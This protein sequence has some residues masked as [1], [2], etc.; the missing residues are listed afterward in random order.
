M[1]WLT[2]IPRPADLRHDESGAVAI[3]LAVAMVVLIGATTFT[4]DVGA[5]YAERQQLQNG[6]DAAAIAIAQ[7]CATG[8]CGS[9]Q[10]TAQTLA[11]ANANDAAA[12]VNTVSFPAPGVVHL[13]AKTRVAGSNAGALALSFAPVLGITSRS[14]A[15]SANATWGSPASGPA[16]LPLAFAPCKFM[17]GGPTQVISMHGDSG[18]TPCTSVS[19]SGQ[20]LPGGFGWLNDPSNSC[21]AN[22]SIAN[23]SLLSGS[24]GSSLPGACAA[25][26]TAHANKTILLPVYSDLGGTGSGA[27][28]VIRGWAAFKLLGWNFPGNNYNNTIYAGAKCSG[29]C[30]GLIGKFVN[31]VSLDDRFTLGGPNLRASVVT[32]TQ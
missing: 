22:V 29:S 7:D 14:V 23:H 15:A 28:Y 16:V 17:L 20:L 6:A 21:S 8:S 25:V 19:P 32:L 18:G 2:R 1:R 30:K 13:T 9:P 24:T 4:L 11:N 26:L 10:A 12:N 27:W 5:L 31:L 3:V